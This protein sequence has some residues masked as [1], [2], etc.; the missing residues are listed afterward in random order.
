MMD[1]AT[2]VNPATI[3]SLVAS[4]RKLSLQ[5]EALQGEDVDRINQLV[6][7]TVNRLKMVDSV[8]KDI[9]RLVCQIYQ[10]S[11]CA[12][13]NATFQLLATL[14]GLKQSTTV[15]S[16]EELLAKGEEEYRMLLACDSW[17]GASK[18]KAKQSFF[19]AIGPKQSCRRCGADDHFIKDCPKPTDALHTAPK[20]GEPTTKEFMNSD[21]T[22]TTRMWCGK[23]GLW[24]KTHITTDHR[25]KAEMAATNAT[26][27]PSV[28]TAAPV[29][30]A[31]NREIAATRARAHLAYEMMAGL[32]QPS[33]N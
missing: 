21:G 33:S 31:S 11:S 4:L 26:P 30:T 13:F 5:D 24:N 19:P 20:P 23:C 3:E 22:T 29:T 25:S 28:S 27:G 2:S 9:F 6:R 17:D 18:R 32:L 16:L 12:E 15:T 10:T 7:G 1:I 14:F 8:P